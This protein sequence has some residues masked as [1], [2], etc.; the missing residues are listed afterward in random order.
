MA[1]QK[2]TIEDR[3]TDFCCAAS[4]EEICAMIRLLETALKLRVAL[5]QG[6]PVKRQ[7]KPKDA[8]QAKPAGVE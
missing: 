1:R 7:R 3:L 8:P 5:S 4:D 2:I 6:D